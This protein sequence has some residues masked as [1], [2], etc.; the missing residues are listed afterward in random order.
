MNENDVLDA[1]YSLKLKNSE[2]YDGIPQRFLID[3]ITILIKPLKDLFNLK[4]RTSFQ[5]G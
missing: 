4:D 5:K 2:G 3:G 1:V